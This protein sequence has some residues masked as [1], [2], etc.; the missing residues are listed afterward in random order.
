[1]TSIIGIELE[2]IELIE[3]D[4]AEWEGLSPELEHA[5]TSAPNKIINKLYRLIKILN[6]LF[7]I[8]HIMA[9]QGHSL[10]KKT[11]ARTTQRIPANPKT[12]TIMA[13]LPPAI[14]TVLIVNDPPLFISPA[15]F[16]YTNCKSSIKGIVL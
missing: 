6:P 10:S 15:H 7:V 8:C 3:P 12:R 1:M 5:V 4:D 13:L 14:N 9:R 11:P 2:L 16:R